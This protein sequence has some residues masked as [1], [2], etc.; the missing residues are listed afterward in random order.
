[1]NGNNNKVSCRT[2]QNAGLLFGPIFFFGPIIIRT[3]YYSDF[4]KFGP[5]IVRTKSIRGLRI[6]R[7]TKVSSP[8]NILYNRFWCIFHIIIIMFFLLRPFQVDDSRRRHNYEPFIAT[9]LGMMAEQGHLSMLLEQ[10][11][12]NYSTVNKRNAPSSVSLLNK[13]KKKFKRK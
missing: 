5:I 12:Q 3:I 7:L 4:L 2:N 8:T 10:Q 6:I 1:M 9:F 11:Q 13:K